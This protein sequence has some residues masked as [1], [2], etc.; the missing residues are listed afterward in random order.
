[1]NRTFKPN[2]QGIT[3]L[4]VI[5]MIV[6][7]L[8]MGTAFVIVANNFNRGAI[9]RIRVNVL[10]GK[11]T[12]QSNALLEDGILQI[13]RGTKL[14]NIDSPLRTENL[15]SDQYGFGVRSFV[16]GDV[17]P[18]LIGENAFVDVAMTSTQGSNADSEG[19]NLLTLSTV[20]GPFD[21]TG[22]GE[23]LRWPSV[24]LYHGPC[25]RIFG[26]NLRRLF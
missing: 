24:V 20:P 26:Q 11:G 2:R 16:A 7:F 15:L 1:M 22:L 21:S 4:F 19:F 10:E 25:K 8:L 9:D 17:A 13:I 23:F 18:Q 5:S 3:L 14:L 6:L 12:E